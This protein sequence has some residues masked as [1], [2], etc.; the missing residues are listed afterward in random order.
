MWREA[1][2]AWLAM[3]AW[4]DGPELAP[5]AAPQDT[6]SDDEV[7]A[8]LEAEVEA[9]NEADAEDAAAV[10]GGS[11]RDARGDLAAA[12]HEFRAQRMAEI[13]ALYVVIVALI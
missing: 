4:K 2:V 13:E 11:G 5:Y 1:P 8:E 9:L 12:F 6:G 10:T 3:G 7:F